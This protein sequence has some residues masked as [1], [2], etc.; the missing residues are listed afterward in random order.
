M[1]AR[2]TPARAGA[3]VV[4]GDFGGGFFLARVGGGGAGSA[5]AGAWAGP[6]AVVGPG[7]ADFTAGFFLARESGAGGAGAVNCFGGDL[8]GSDEVF[9][10]V[11]ESGAVVGAE[12]RGFVV[13]V[14][15]GEVGEN[16]VEAARTRSLMLGEYEIFFFSEGSKWWKNP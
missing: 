13:A 9:V 11:A 4:D 14:V 5:G 12:A 6:C 16:C 8:G 2:G 10:R 15:L 7:V 1:I 3:G